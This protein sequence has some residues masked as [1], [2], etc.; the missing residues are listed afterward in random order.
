MIQGNDFLTELFCVL[1]VIVVVI[2]ICVIYSK[3]KKGDNLIVNT[4]V[5]TADAGTL[6]STQAVTDS[7]IS[8]RNTVHYGKWNGKHIR[9]Q[10]FVWC[11]GKYTGQHDGGWKRGASPRAVIP[12][13]AFQMKAVTKVT[14]RMAALPRVMAAITADQLTVSHRTA[15]LIITSLVQET[16]N[17][18]SAS[19]GV[20]VSA[21]NVYDYL[22]TMKPS[23][24]GLSKDF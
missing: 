17:S 24:F 14:H 23:A 10:Y 2:V 3:K 21:D 9:Q 11:I 5:S 12:E 1:L 16:G 15:I 7:A 19:A 6:Q 22:K 13:T 20:Y 18:N 8:G 4:S